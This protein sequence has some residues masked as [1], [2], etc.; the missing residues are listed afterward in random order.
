MTDSQLLGNFVAG[1]DESAFRALVDR[2]GPRVLK[3]CWGILRD[4]HEVEDTFQATFLVLARKAPTIRDPEGLGSWLHGV[5]FR[6]AAR[7][8]RGAARRRK[9]E[10][11]HAELRPT[12]GAP[13]RSWEDEGRVVIEEL[14]QLPRPYRDPIELCYLR[15]LSHEEAASRLGWPLGTLKT[16]LVRG[17]RRLR[18]RLDRR[19]IAT[20]GALLLL[21]LLSGKAQAVPEE[22][23]AS[24]IEAMRLGLSG[25]A[26]ALAPHAARAS[27]LVRGRRRAVFGPRRLAMLLTL[28][29]G[30][31]AASWGITAYG[32]ARAAEAEEIASIPAGLMDVLNVDCR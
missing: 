5:A 21:L 17:R 3:V 6:L 9:H 28:L 27:R 20:A 4:P 15:G 22:L 8:R 31:I 29:G 30:T 25:R 2:H 14:G 12:P 26:G 16:R 10:R 19:G 1:H 24:T 7:A 32:R 23:A 18:D 11:R 13:E